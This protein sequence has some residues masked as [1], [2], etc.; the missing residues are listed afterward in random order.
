M[1]VKFDRWAVGAAICVLVLLLWNVAGA[2]SMRRDSVTAEI[3]GNL[4][5]TSAGSD[6]I[7]P[8]LIWRKI[9]AGQLAVCA[10]ADAYEGI[11]TVTF[12]RGELAKSLHPSFL[13]PKWMFHLV[14]GDSVYFPMRVKPYDS[15]LTAVGGTDGAVMKIDDR[16]NPKYFF[17]T[18]RRVMVFPRQNKPAE[19]TDTF[20]VMGNRSAPPLTQDAD[21]MVIHP[22]YRE[23][24]IDWVCWQIE[25]MR[26]NYDAAAA[27]RKDYMLEVGMSE[28]QGVGQ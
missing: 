28:A 21:T 19:L 20:I 24:V 15:L 11:D 16:D 2:Q 25:K 12:T 10:V 18:G 23:A 27:H 9:N 6:K 4:N 26:G 8:S 22:A 14:G 13:R 5:L 3:M 7:T 17:F 1:D